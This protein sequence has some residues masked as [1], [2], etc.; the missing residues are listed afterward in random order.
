MGEHLS[1]KLTF[2]N[3][4]VIAFGKASSI[5]VMGGLVEGKV[6]QCYDVWF[7]VVP[8]FTNWAFKFIQDM[9]RTIVHI[10]YS[11]LVLKVIEDWTVKK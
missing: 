6:C 7:T 4:V 9:F 5:R 2:L 3:G 11:K 8:T 10:K 1:Y